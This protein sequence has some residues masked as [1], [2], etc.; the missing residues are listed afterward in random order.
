MQTTRGSNIGGDRR[1]HTG[2]FLSRYGKPKTG[3]EEEEEFDKE[4][5]DT[6]VY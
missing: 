1:L 5:P 6:N 3:N 2:Y 4:V